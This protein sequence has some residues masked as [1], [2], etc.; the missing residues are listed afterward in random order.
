MYDFHFTKYALI[1][2][3]SR[4]ATLWSLAS[5]TCI[6]LTACGVASHVLVIRCDEDESLVVNNTTEVVVTLSILT[7]AALLELVQ[8]LLYWTAIWASILCLSVSQTTSNVKHKGK[9]LHDEIQRDTYEDWCLL[10]IRQTLLATQAWA[11]LFT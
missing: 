3:R 8:M 2:Y 6:S 1:Y 4:A 9:L 11:V 5:F 7:C 10:C